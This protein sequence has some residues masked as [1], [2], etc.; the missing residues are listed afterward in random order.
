MKFFSGQKSTQYFEDIKNR[1]KAEIESLSDTEIIT[2]DFEEWKD[3]LRRIFQNHKMMIV[4]ILY[5][6]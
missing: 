2:C 1:I 4:D 6:N 5:W 3:L